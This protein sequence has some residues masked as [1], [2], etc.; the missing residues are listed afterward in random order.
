MTTRFRLTCTFIIMLFGRNS[1]LIL[2]RLMLVS[3]QYIL[4]VY[5]RY[6]LNRGKCLEVFAPSSKIVCSKLDAVS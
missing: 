5:L 6:I 2:R 3:N 1:L 4:A